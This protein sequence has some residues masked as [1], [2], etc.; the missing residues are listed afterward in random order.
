MN[1]SFRGLF[2]SNL[3]L[4]NTVLNI[5]CF[6]VFIT[7]VS[8]AQT[9]CTITGLET[10]YCFNDVPDTIYSYPSGG[11]FS[12]AGMVDSI[13][14]PS[15]AGAG[16]HLIR[17]TSPDGC[18]S[19]LFVT[20]IAN[21][22]APTVIGDTICSGQSTTLTANGTG[23][24]SWYYDPLLNNIASLSN[25]FVTAG[26]TA[27]GLN[28]YV[29]Q[30]INGCESNPAIA[31]VIV[32]P[33]PV[34]PDANG[35]FICFGDS[36]ILTSFGSGGTM[37]WYDMSL[38]D[39][40]DSANTYQT[41]A[42]S[43]TTSYYVVEINAFGCRSNYIPAT[44]I[45]FPEPST[46][47]V[48]SPVI[49]CQGENV[50]LTA[51]G[52][53]A[54]ELVFYDDNFNQLLA[55][56]MNGFRTRFFNA[57]F[58]SAGVYT[59]FVTER[60]INCES[61]PVA[62]RVE[63]IAPASSPTVNDTT[64]CQGNSTLLSVNG[65]ALYYWY[66]DPALT[67]LSYAGSAFQ[68]PNLNASTSYYVSEIDAFGCRSL[69][70]TVTVTV[71]STPSNP[72]V[73]NDTIC[74][75]QTAI[76]TAAGSG[77]T[78]KWYSG[79]IGN[80]INTGNTYTTNQLFQTTNYFINETDAFGCVS[81][82][83]PFQIFIR[84]NPPAPNV[85]SPLNFCEGEAMFLES[86]GSGSGTLNF[87][88]SSNTLLSSVNM[89]TNGYVRYNL[90]SLT[91]GIYS[92]Y[93]LENDGNC[94][95]DTASISLIVNSRPVAPVVVNK[96][97]CD[98]TS[99]I[100]NGTG[101][102]ILSWYADAALS[103]LLL[104]GNVYTTPILTADST[105]YFVT[106]TNANGCRSVADTVK[107][108]TVNEPVITSVTND[109]VCSGLAATLSAIS[110]GGSLSWFD[111]SF[112][113]VL[114]TGNTLQT[115]PLAQNTIYYVV[116]TNA[117]GC[118]SN[119]RAVTGVVR[120][121]PDAPGINSVR[122]CENEIIRLTST[123]TGI[124]TM[125][126]YN[127]NFQIIDSTLM[128][129]V[130]TH[131][132]DTIGLNS[133]SYVF[134][135]AQNNGICQSAFS[136]INV[137]VDSASASPIVRDTAICAGT[138][139]TLTAL[140]NTVRWYADP[141]M[142]ILLSVGS[143]FNTPVL[144]DTTVY[145]VSSNS[146]GC[147][148]FPSTLTV[149]AKPSPQIPTAVNDTV[150]A[151]GSAQLIANSVTG[152]VQWFIDPAGLNLT[153]T[154]DTLDIGIVYQSSNYYVNAIDANG[155]S[156]PLLGITVVALPVL[157]PPTA[158]DVSVCFGDTVIISASGSGNGFLIFY[159]T[160][161]AEI[162]I[163]TM[164]VVN[165]SGSFNLGALPTGNYTFYTAE[166]NVN[167]T[168]VRTPIN[169]RVKPIPAT[170]SIFND[171]PV[172]EGEDIFLQSN[173]VPFA[174]YTW[175]GPNGLVGNQQ[176]IQII[177]SAMVDSGSYTINIIVDGCTSVDTVTEVVVNRRPILS[178]ISDNG[179][180]CQGD[181]LLLTTDTVAAV[182]Y[183]WSGPNG[184]VSNLQNPALDSVYENQHHGF[185]NLVLV[186]SLTACESEMLS[187][188]VVV[189]NLPATGLA[190]NTGPACNGDSVNL[191]VQ[192]V[193]GAN[194]EWSGPNGFS[195]TDRL[196]TLSSLTPEM[197]GL[198]AV[199]VTAY[200]CS[201]IAE[202]NVI[203][204]TLDSA[205]VF[206]DTTIE[207]GYQVQLIAAGGIDYEWLPDSFLNDYRIY[208][209]ICNP[210]D[211][212]RFDYEVQITD[213]NGC[214][215]T[216]GVTV[217]VIASD[218]P[219][220]PDLYTPNNDGVNDFWEVNFLQVIDEEHTVEIYSRGG[221]RVFYTENYTNNWNGT[222]FKTGAL[223]PDGTYYY[224]IRLSSGTE[225]KGPVTIK[226]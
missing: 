185:Y 76:L 55:V 180:L 166:Q 167:C 104:T 150:C 67:S 186:D 52:S 30:T 62:I 11:T 69:A 7:N 216:L 56:Q 178:S 182:I 77:G 121:K 9:P 187:T 40:L 222:H 75:G 61:N 199:T 165:N 63:V 169:V 92:F 183:N 117:F 24:I 220:I 133:G 119:P 126:F 90:A 177:E 105:S 212:G 39:V 140:G 194:Y 225:Y 204:N 175:T 163:D 173:F 136:L 44:A 144:N 83:V 159:D 217:T 29:T 2:Y 32:H 127:S 79:T 125:Y 197:E 70:D 96:T 207:L 21:P 37:V 111:A 19:L 59:Y 99:T 80:L 215:D 88:N 110:S 25:P 157:T 102:G 36:A 71:R 31:Q 134:Y 5:I 34:D 116:E 78:I 100:L 22:S 8:K 164:S 147:E 152:T 226:R 42:L 168:S 213:F 43:Q 46:P 135:S 91:I 192:T 23:Q 106:Q 64:I 118:Q 179:P 130:L 181:S 214:K 72:I 84:S 195:S 146:N 51:T 161:L 103:N 155:C 115:F 98:S 20:V 137:L 54:G 33:T 74:E 16:S 1:K 171:S 86:S 176:N 38:I 223:L 184:F 128:G 170:P 138:S 123:G 15:L 206:R 201:T 101:S 107:I 149:F 154:G 113:T 219:I 198:Y 45:V 141:S 218:D 60:D 3:N 124:G 81:N 82:P 93:V 58:L 95:S 120:Q 122:V 66:S 10:R 221:L 131:Y 145:Y 191:L 13:F 148:S 200:G 57:G 188:L 14:N 94:S 114:S 49:V 4:F 26:L 41:P 196:V 97:I 28:Y 53:G 174:I 172:C 210:S 151:G 203:V 139:L 68:T 202:T 160:L 209:P 211:T 153:A 193:Y 35:D 208:N 18:I 87:Y 27:P 6:A 129:G 65:S 189:N 224:L 109:T 17:Y 50:V 85:I 205:V 142:T 158:L 48:L 190:L 112:T 108:F 162:D 132:F 12:G 47:T 89:S 73:A 156:S 143:I